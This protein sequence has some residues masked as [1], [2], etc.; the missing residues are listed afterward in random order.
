ME[1]GPALFRKDVPFMMHLEGTINGTPFTVEGKGTGNS[2]NGHHQGKWVC[3]SG[4]L[5]MSWAALSTS[6]GYGYKCFTNFPNGI[7]HFYQQCMPE[8]WSQE[9]EISFEG[10]GILKTRHEIS[11][12]KGTVIN[13]VKVEGTGF[14]ADSPV[15][16]DGLAVFLPSTEMSY[17]L[18]DGIRSVTL[19][20]FPLKNAE[21]KYLFTTQRSTHKQLSGSRKV[22]IPG[23][24]FIRLQ[25]KQYKDVDDSSDHIIME[26]RLEGYDYKLIE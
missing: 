9:R 13:K 16:N 19:L 12:V 2:Q 21:G 3:T 10:D 6:L 18:E 11:Y 4:T 23:H 7:P 1:A 22:Q 17:P 14:N 20:L 5:P 15:L 26:E 25:A 24:H 8:G